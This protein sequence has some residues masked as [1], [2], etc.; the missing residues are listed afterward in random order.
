MPDDVTFVEM[1][2]RD[3]LDS[4]DHVPRFDQTRHLSERQINLRDV[5]RDHG[6]TAVADSCHE[7]LHLLG[8]RVLCFIEDDES[9]VKGSTAHERDRSDFNHTTFDMAVDALDVEH[10]V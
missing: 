10:I 6:L 5:A 3:T 8:C 7:H 9:I 2:E 4:G 1:N